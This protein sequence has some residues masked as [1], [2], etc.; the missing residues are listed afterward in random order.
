MLTATSC[1]SEGSGVEEIPGGAA[2]GGGDTWDIPTKDADATG[3]GSHH[4]EKKRGRER[5]ASR[6]ENPSGDYSGVGIREGAPKDSGVTENPG[7]DRNGVGGGVELP[8][9]IDTPRVEEFP[10]EGETTKVT[11]EGDGVRGANERGQ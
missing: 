5:V 2:A 10:W 8:R 1:E 9:G 3:A 7:G 6:R 11:P 4:G